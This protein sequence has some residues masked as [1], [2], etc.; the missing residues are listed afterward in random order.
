[1]QENSNWYWKQQS[2]QHNIIVSTR[3]IIHP[4]IDVAR[5]TYVQ[6][7]PK[8]VSNRIEGKK[9]IHRHPIYMTDADYDYILDE[10]E[11][12]EKMGLNVM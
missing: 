1:M 10:I 12:R 9:A 8:T 7:I 5:I 6:D 11:L 2:L 4:C 3:T